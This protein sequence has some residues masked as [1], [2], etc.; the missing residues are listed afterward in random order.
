MHLAKPGLFP[1]EPG[2]AIQRAQTVRQVADYE[3]SP[4]PHDDATGT[5]RA[6]ESFVATAAA[7]VAGFYQR[8]SGPTP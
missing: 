5:V 1:A 3:A 2:R 8:P 4:V 7:L 6:A